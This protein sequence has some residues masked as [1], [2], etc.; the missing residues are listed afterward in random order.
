MIQSGLEDYEQGLHT[1]GSCLVRI[2]SP[3]LKKAGLLA[4]VCDA[5]QAAELELYQL[6]A[7]E[8]NQAHS[9]YNALIR[10][11]ISFEHALDHKS[12][13]AAIRSVKVLEDRELF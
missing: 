7:H 13:K 5:G 2:A 12:K 4:R 8:G 1:I 6:L 3:R 11:L 10:E 9:R